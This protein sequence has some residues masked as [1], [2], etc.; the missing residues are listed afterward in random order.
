[1][2]Q[3]A[4]TGIPCRRAAATAGARTADTAQQQQQHP[5]YFVVPQHG[6]NFQEWWTKNSALAVDHI[7]AGSFDTA[8]QLLNRQAAIVHFAPLKPLFMSI[9]QSSRTSL[10]GVNP[11]DHL[12]MPLL[13]NWTTD[14]QWKNSLPMLSMTPQA[15]FEL[16]QPAYRAMTDGRFAEAMQLFARILQLCLLV[17]AGNRREA[18]EVLCPCLQWYIIV[19]NMRIFFNL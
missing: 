17:V 15:V 19:L 12:L 14:Q 6:V 8:M 7:A 10:D 9:Y 3:V 16:L 13:R 11:G 4:I 5:Q 1:M 18:D 2:K